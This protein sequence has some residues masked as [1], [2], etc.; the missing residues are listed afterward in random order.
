MKK[1]QNNTGCALERVVWVSSPET[2]MTRVSFPLVLYS[3]IHNCVNNI[4]NLHISLLL[5][6]KKKAKLKDNKN[7]NV[8]LVNQWEYNSQ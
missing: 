1:G 3:G 7:R 8:T 4:N 5:G 6:K 2:R